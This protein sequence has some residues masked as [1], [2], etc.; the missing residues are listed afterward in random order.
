MKKA[1][2]VMLLLVMPFA[3]MAQS[4]APA[5]SPEMKK[6]NFLL[7]KWRGEGWIEFG[8]GQRRTFTESETV[9]SK[10]D[11]LVL[12]IEG[13]GKNKDGATIHNAFA[14]A[15]YDREGKVFRWQAYRGDGNQMSAEPKVGEN[16]LVWGFRDPRA[17]EI[18]FTISLNEKGQWFEI[19]EMS[20]DGKTWRKFFEMTLSRVG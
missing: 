4:H 9:E 5:Q 17:G 8:A 13:L 1:L 12:V 6:L 20:R 15:S 7:G 16:S 18:R 19:G 2:P 11:G 10:L 14:V 3:S